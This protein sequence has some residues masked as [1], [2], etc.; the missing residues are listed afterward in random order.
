[1]A[2]LSLNRAG[3]EG[4]GEHDRLIGD[5]R[6]RAGGEGHRVGTVRNDNAGELGSL[7]VL[8]EHRKRHAQLWMTAGLL[9]SAPVEEKVMS[10]ISVK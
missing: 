6:E 9:M 2:S 4:T 8:D 3:C 5:L 10:I 7:E 1:V